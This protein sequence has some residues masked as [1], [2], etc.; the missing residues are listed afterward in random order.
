LMSL[1]YRPLRYQL[2]LIPPMCALAAL[3]MDS[4]I[5]AFN[6][7]R[8]SSTGILF[9]ISF[10]VALMFLINYLITTLHRLSGKAIQLSSSLVI[11]VIATLLLGG[12]YYWLFARSQV[13]TKKVASSQSK[14]FATGHRVLIVLILLLASLVV[15]GWQY[16]SWASLP[17]YSLNRSSVDL[18]R[19]LSD[20]AVISGPYGPALV[21]DNKLKNIIHMFGV[22]KPDPQL[23][24]TYP[25]THL[26]LE[27]GGNRDR[28]FQD[29]PE[30]MNKAKIVTTYWLRNIPVDIYRIGEWTGNLKTKG[31]PL[32]DFER[33]K[34]LIEGEK[35]DSA[36]A[37]LVDFV[38]RNPENYSGYHALA[39]IYYDR[40]EYKKALLSLEQAAEFNSTDFM[41]HQLMGAVYFTLASQTGQESNQLSGIEEWEMALR[42]FPQNVQL[43]E[44]LRQ[45]K[46]Y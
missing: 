13:A 2:Y 15:N 33:V 29:Y 37:L 36:L 18:G 27:R 16:I 45:I 38:S 34:L 9:W 32:S 20:E 46:G 31:Y 5:S 10:V 22:S 39:Q 25:I 42:L 19:I 44:Q 43:A 11:S 30:V 40:G 21:W 8:K 17:T 3:W 28:A 26:A 23:F 6:T 41:V 14:T 24:H 1:N 12:I 7:K 35:T 4:L